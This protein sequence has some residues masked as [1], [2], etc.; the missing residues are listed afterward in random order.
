MS[1]RTP[2]NN[3]EVHI[4]GGH[5]DLQGMGHLGRTVHLVLLGPCTA[6]MDRLPRGMAHR[7]TC[8]M[9]NSNTP[10]CIVYIWVGC[11]MEEANSS[12]RGKGTGMRTRLANLA[13]LNH[14]HSF[15]MQ[16]FVALKTPAVGIEEVL[17]YYVTN[18]Y[19]LDDWRPSRILA[20]GYSIAWLG[21]P[22]LLSWGMI[23]FWKAD[24]E[25]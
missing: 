19:D 4:L 2:H 1:Y 21:K 14:K 20:N 7:T 9:G 23:S 15:P 18:V 17:C 10:S 8:R 12:C 3:P 22:K 11:C 5:M 16:I 13:Y 24:V 6:R 25:R